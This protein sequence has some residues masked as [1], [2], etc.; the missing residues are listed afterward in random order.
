MVEE[1]RRTYSRE[2]TEKALRGSI[3]KWHNILH[4]DG[5]DKN[6]ANCPLCRLFGMGNGCEE[7]PVA[8]KVEQFHCHGTPWQSWQQHQGAQH[9]G[10]RRKIHCPTC[11]E[12]AQAEY[13]F[14]K[15]LLIDYLSTRAKIKDDDYLYVCPDC[16]CTLEQMPRGKL[17]SCEVECPKCTTLTDSSRWHPVERVVKKSAGKK[18]EWE[19]I[20]ERITWKVNAACGDFWLVGTDPHGKEMED[21]ILVVSNNIHLEL[22]TSQPDYQ[23]KH[24]QSGQFF[25]ILKR[26]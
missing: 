2:T 6:D 7:C 22:N 21:G 8:V 14:L 19:D 11:R 15:D 18:E 16:F 25:R 17:Y 3:E 1:T 12:L 5:E 10:K 9:S 26:V 23:I 20:T 13:D 4:S 24:K